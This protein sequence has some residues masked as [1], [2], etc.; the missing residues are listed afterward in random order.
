MKERIV[1]LCAHNDDQIVGMGGTVAKYAKE[2]KE[3][4][5]IV[6]SYGEISHP[7]LKEN[8]IRETRKI[9]A[10][11]A[12]Q[13]LGEK[14][15]MFLGLKEGMFAEELKQKNFLEKLSKRIKKLNP[16]KIFTH[17]IDDPHPDHKAVYNFT[18]ELIDKMNYKKEVYTYNI[19]NLFINFRKR[20]SP[21]LVVDVSGTFKK[22]MKAFEKHKSQRLAMLLL[23]WNIYL[24]G[25]INGL[26]NGVKYAEVFYRIK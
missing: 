6:F 18:M 20:Q 12:K 15:V 21:K 11:R 13:V 14:E 3:I 2:G 16:E 10:K 17:S 9:E 8:V 7:H 1:I 25:I 4:Y 19:W 22:K 24:Q 26:R 23:T 5:T